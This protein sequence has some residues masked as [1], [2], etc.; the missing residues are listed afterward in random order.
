MHV[1]PGRG[2]HAG[3]VHHLLRHGFVHGHAA[4]Q[5]ARAGVRHAQQVQRG[6]DAAILA[7]SA[8]ERQ[9]HD[10][11]H[12][13]HR[14]HVLAQ[15]T[16]ALVDAAAPH[17]LQIRL[18]A[19]HPAAAAQAVRRVKDVLQPPVVLLQPQKHIHQNSLM[20]PLPQRSA[21]ACAAG[22]RH[23]ALRGQSSGQYDD[24]H[25]SSLAFRRSGRKTALSAHV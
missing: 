25:A 8:V 24:L 5:I 7:A 17:R 2:T 23:L 16:G 11:R 9:E 1:T 12:A 3:G 15:H 10:V 14:Q 19:L 18:Y 4:A 21:H 13:A 20:S 22:Q 6:L